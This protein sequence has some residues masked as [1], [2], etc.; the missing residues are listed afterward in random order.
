[1]AA[2]KVSIF[3]DMMHRP[4]LDEGQPQR[5]GTKK[6]QANHDGVGV[7]DGVGQ[8]AGVVVSVS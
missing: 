2:N 4:V 6:L 8:A 1:M 5:R 3:P 7:G